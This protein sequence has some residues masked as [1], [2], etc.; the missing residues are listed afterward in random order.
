MKSNWSFHTDA[1]G[2]GEALNRNS[3]NPPMPRPQIRALAICL[4]L[5]GDRILV[6][7]VRDPVKGVSFCRP[8]GGGIESGETGVQAV[9]REIREE[10]G[11]ELIP[12]ALPISCARELLRMRLNRSYM[13]SPPTAR[14]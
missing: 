7:E 3:D 8:L 9:V 5:D 11:A 6:S 14:G 2:A 4:F 1:C 10:I 12:R 13:D